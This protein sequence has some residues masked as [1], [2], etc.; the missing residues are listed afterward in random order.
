MG[1]THY[2]KHDELNQDK[3]NDFIKDAKKII[4][5]ST[6]PIDLQAAGGEVLFLNGQKPE[7][8][9]TFIIEREQT[10]SDFCKTARRPYDEVVVAILMLA[11]ET[12]AGFSWSSDGSDEEHKDG[13]NLLQLANLGYEE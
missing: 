12:F 4:Q 6:V 13:A 5:T 8:W 3:W 9:E 7:D 10:D 2:W 11:D 1:Y